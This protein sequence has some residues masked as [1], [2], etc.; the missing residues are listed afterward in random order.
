MLQ[1]FSYGSALQSGIKLLVPSL[2]ASPLT[3]AVYD[4]LSAWY[5]LPIRVQVGQDKRRFFLFQREGDAGLEFLVPY[6]SHFTNSDFLEDVVTHGI[7]SCSHGSGVWYKV[8]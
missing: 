3:V 7:Y 8:I 2:I 6:I 5:D 4:K 1:N